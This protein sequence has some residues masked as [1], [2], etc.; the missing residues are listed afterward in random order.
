MCASEIATHVGWPCCGLLNVSHC[1]AHAGLTGL[2]SLKL[3]CSDDDDN[4]IDN[5][6]GIKI[7]PYIPG[8]ASLPQ[9]TRLHLGPC[10]PPLLAKLPAQLQTLE[11][12]VSY[13]T[14][15]PEPLFQLGHLTAMS[16]LRLFID[17]DI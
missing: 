11:L 7:D 12:D 6:Q 17:D 5:E 14:D 9:L 16:C 1:S 4:D 10:S 8:I 13:V 15:Q 3:S 2:Q